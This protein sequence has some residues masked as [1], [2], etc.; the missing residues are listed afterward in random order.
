[1]Q[2]YRIGKRTQGVKYLKIFF[3][4][5]HDNRPESEGK[6]MYV[7]FYYAK[8]RIKQA[9]LKFINTSFSY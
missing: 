2:N 4:I 6:E 5:D 9:S 3:T 1:M 8:I 7:K